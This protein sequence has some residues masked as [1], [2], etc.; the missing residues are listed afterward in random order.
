MK[1]AVLAC[2]MILGASQV[3][4]CPIQSKAGLLVAQGVDA[5]A[6]HLSFERLAVS[7]PL[8]FVVEV[9]SA[10][11]GTPL[12]VAFDASMPAHQHGMNYTVDITKQD[13]TTFL[14]D[15]VVFHMPGVWEVQIDVQGPDGAH[16]FFKELQVK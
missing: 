2:G 11:G 6:A 10:D 4:A 7:E 8:A 12:D 5:P 15:N 13:E 1:A 14:I 3:V 9:C 16:T